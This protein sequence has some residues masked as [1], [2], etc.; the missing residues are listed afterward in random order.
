MAVIQARTAK[1]ETRARCGRPWAIPPQSTSGRGASEF[2]GT[3]ARRILDGKA[4]RSWTRRCFG[5]PENESGG[6]RTDPRLG[7]KPD[8]V[9]GAA[10]LLLAFD[11]THAPLGGGLDAGGLALVVGVARVG[12]EA[13]GVGLVFVSF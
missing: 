4:A 6:R 13:A 2:T 5:C 11:E 1:I 3:V 10:G 7:W 12:I 8:G 9:G